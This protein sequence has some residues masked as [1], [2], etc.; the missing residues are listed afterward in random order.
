MSLGVRG[1]WDDDRAFTRRAEEWLRACLCLPV[2]QAVLP[3][4]R[5]YDMDPDPLIDAVLER[6]IALRGAYLEWRPFGTYRGDDFPCGEWAI[7]ERRL[8]EQVDQA[9]TEALGLAAG[10]E[11]HLEAALADL[12]REV[13]VHGD[14]MPCAR[15]PSVA[16]LL[17]Q[18]VLLRHRKAQSRLYRMIERRCDFCPKWI[19]AGL[20]GSRCEPCARH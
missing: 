18:S 8:R 11:V 19:R 17:P 16:E 7:N 20:R 12:A 4:A 13:E 6:C 14:A 9:V 5:R 10:G 2:A 15:E 1:A 3:A